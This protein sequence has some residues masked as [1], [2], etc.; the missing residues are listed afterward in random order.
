MPACM[1]ADITVVDPE[2]MTVYGRRSYPTLAA[3]GGKMLAVSRP[4]QALEGD[5]QPSLLVLIEFATAKQAREWVV[6]PECQPARQ[7]APS[8]G[9]DESH[10]AGG[11]R[12]RESLAGPRAFAR[13]RRAGAADTEGGAAR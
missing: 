5:R 2:A 6:S 8:G 10:P 12:N 7:A 4:P 1:V 9:Q 13:V 11:E 3:A